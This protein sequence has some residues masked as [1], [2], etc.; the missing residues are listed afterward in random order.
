MS[1]IFCSKRLQIFSCSNFKAEKGLFDLIQNEAQ[2][3]VMSTPKKIFIKKAFEKM[4]DDS[5]RP[6]A[7]LAH[8]LKLS[9]E[10][11]LLINIIYFFYLL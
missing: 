1:H 2:M 11:I 6:V 9:C 5:L 3:N 10:F 4:S 7:E 8:N